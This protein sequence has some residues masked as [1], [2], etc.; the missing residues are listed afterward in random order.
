MGA[1][2][3]AMR[4]VATLKGQA[5]VRQR[6]VAEAVRVDVPLGIGRTLLQSLLDCTDP[7]AHPC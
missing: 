1:A 4:A 3:L 5:V 2:A 6:E 7:V